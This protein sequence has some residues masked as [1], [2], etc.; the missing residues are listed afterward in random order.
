MVKQAS[1]GFAYDDYSSVGKLLQMEKT[2][3]LIVKLSDI[4][5]TLSK[6][7]ALT[8]FLFAKDGLAS[9]LDTPQKIGLTKKQYY[10]RLKQLVELGLLSK[11]ENKYMHTAL[12]NIIYAKHLLGLLHSMKISK[13]LEMIDLL[14]RSSKFKSEEITNFVSKLNPEMSLDKSHDLERHH[15]TITTAF[16]SM[17]RSVTEIVEFAEKE[18]ILVTRFQNDLIINAILKKAERGVQVKVISDIN[19][20]E[21]YFQLE[22]DKIKLNDKNSEERIN[23]VSNP[24]YPYKIERRYSKTPYCMLIVDEK[25]IGMEIV[26]TYESNKFKLAIFGTDTVFSS[27]MKSEFE[28]MWKYATVNPP[29]INKS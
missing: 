9:E 4:L 26:D 16:E 13:E 5:S 24:F 20:V 1:S 28:K 21:G 22:K 29:Q 15:F 8:I 12:G 10:T 17:V 18:I 6:N 2:P 27:Q 3:Q 7:D 23:V 19:M 14:K 11:S 25:H